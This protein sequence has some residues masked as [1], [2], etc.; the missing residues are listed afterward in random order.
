MPSDFNFEIQLDSK[1]YVINGYNNT[2]SKG[3]DWDRDTTIS[4]DIGEVLKEKVYSALVKLDINKYPE[5]Y[6]PTT[7]TRIYPS[8]EYSVVYTISGITKSV[9]WT[10]NTESNEKEAKALRK[11]FNSI[12]EELIGNEKVQNL[13]KTNRL[14]L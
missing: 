11:F 3:F 2:L 8:F 12:S 14:A 13:P 5:N 4:F 7:T 1:L 6:A 9:S 10:E